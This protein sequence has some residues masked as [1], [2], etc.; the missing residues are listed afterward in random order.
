MSKTILNPSFNEWLTDVTNSVYLSQKKI[1]SKK[2]K[3]FLRRAYEINV[4]RE[5]YFTV[6]DFI[7]MKPNNFRQYI[8]KWKEYIVKVID[9]RPSFYCL[10]GIHTDN[11]TE[12]H[13][14]TDSISKEFEQILSELKQQPP[15]I[16]NIRIETMTNGLYEA[17]LK[18]RIPNKQNKG[19]H[20][21]IPLI[22]TKLKCKVSVYKTGRMLV[23][24]SCTHNPLEY[25]TAGFDDMIEYLA[26][27][28]QHLMGYANVD[29][30]ID[31]VRRWRITFYHFNRDG[32]TINSPIFKYCIEDLQAHTVTYLHK[33]ESGENVLRH[34]EYK[35]LKENNTIEEEQDKAIML[36]LEALENQFI[37]D[38]TKHPVEFKKASKL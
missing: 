12:N 25:S 28:K 6:D 35:S 21:T 14:V 4:V 9:S 23:M 30:I 19:I 16:H 22:D 8:R 18:I 3:T 29:F 20:Y 15:M 37:D 7:G 38:D 5:N 2:D 34:E 32:I 11:L 10:K 26:Q 1:I 27:V 17:L 33:L 13:T 31:K 24:L 36:K